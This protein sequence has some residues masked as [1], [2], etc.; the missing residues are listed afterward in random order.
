MKWFSKDYQQIWIM[1]DPRNSKIY[2][3]TV[4]YIVSAVS[5]LCIAYNLKTFSWY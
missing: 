5:M 2:F 1:Q 3:E 4:P